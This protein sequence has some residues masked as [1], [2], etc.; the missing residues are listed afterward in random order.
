M[1][2]KKLTSFVSRKN[3]KKKNIPKKRKIVSTTNPR[4]NTGTGRRRR[5][6]PPAPK[7][8][9]IYLERPLNVVNSHTAEEFLYEQVLEW[10]R[11]KYQDN[12]TT[13]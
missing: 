7:P 5:D 8:K 13:P 11:M 4:K 1:V 9:P 12:E 6:L 3:S 2:K 10:R